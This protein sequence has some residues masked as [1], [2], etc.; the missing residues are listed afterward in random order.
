MKNLVLRMR[1]LVIVSIFAI[2]LGIGPGCVINKPCYKDFVKNRQFSFVDW[3]TNPARNTIVFKNDTAFDYANGQLLHVGKV[4][5][6]SCNSYLL[7]TVE[8]ANGFYKPGDTIRNNI[9]EK[10]QDTLKIETTV[11]GLSVISGMYRLKMDS[12]R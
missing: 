5:W 9:L 1:L 3:V 4:V 11:R 2:G 6:V 8:S 12:L 10:Q 7:I